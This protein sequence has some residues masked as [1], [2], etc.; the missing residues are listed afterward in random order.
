MA[1]VD[2]VL[3]PSTWN[4]VFATCVIDVEGLF[5]RRTCLD[6]FAKSRMK[7]KRL[8]MASTACQ[9]CHFSLNG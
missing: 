5:V 7:P 9:N 3:E 2:P 8:L 4:C 6:A 1:P